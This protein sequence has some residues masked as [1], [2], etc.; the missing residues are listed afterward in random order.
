MSEPIKVLIVDDSATVRRLLTALI[1][2]DGRMR[3]VGVAPDPYVAREEIKRLNPDV[4]TLDVE[5]PRMDGLTFLKNLMR[6]RPMPVVMVSSLTDRGAEVTLS[7]LE[8]GAVDFVCK[9]RHDLVNT[10]GS[11]GL[12]LTDKI[13]AAAKARVRPYVPAKKISAGAQAVKPVLLNKTSLVRQ[14][15][16]IGASTG[17]TEAIKD[18]LMNLPPDMP[19]VLITQHMPASFSGAFARRMDSV[20]VLS[21]QEASDGLEVCNGHVYIAPGDRH[22]LLSRANGRLRIVLDDGAPVNRH[23]PSVDVMFDS[24]METMGADVTAVLLTGMGD[25]GARGMKR[26]REAGAATIAQDQ[27]SSVV[28]GMPGSAVR[29]EA[30]QLVLPLN[31]IAAKVIGLVAKAPGSSFTG[32]ALKRHYG[33]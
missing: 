25:D 11:Y 28:W 4:L 21:V 9:P 10:L 16:A 17:G 27:K 18:V 12:D 26:L 31:T 15:V 1:E 5:M 2:R 33:S 13:A 19:P 24:V 14:V 3:V 6:L 22:M 32:T 23:K 29:L 7:A 20:S 30:A 8:V